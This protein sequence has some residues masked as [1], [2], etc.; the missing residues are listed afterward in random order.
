[1]A[2]NRVGEAQAEVNVSKVLTVKRSAKM[3]I[4]TWMLLVGKT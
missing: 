1:M 3:K 4:W 2:E